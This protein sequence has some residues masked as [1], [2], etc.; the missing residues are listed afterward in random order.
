MSQVIFG[1]LEDLLSIGTPSSGYIVAYDLDGVLKQK[2]V[3]GNI[4]PIGNTS[5]YSLDE[6]LAAGN[7]SGTYS[8]IMGTSS[9]IR[10]A[11]GGG[12]IHFDYPGA[13]AVSITTDGASYSE[14]YLTL[15]GDY[16]KLNYKYSGASGMLLQA[17]TAGE[18]LIN[19]P[20]GTI[21]HVNG[22][23]FIKS[24]V[25]TFS[26]PDTPKYST[27]ISSRGSTVNNGIV[28]SVVL[29]GQN[30][31]ASTNNTVYV[32]SLNVN[33][34]YT[35]PTTDGSN[36]YVLKTDGSGNVTWQSDL[37]TS[38]WA[39]V[40][41]QGN[42]SSADV[43]ISDGNKIKSQDSAVIVDFNNGEKFQAGFTE[44]FTQS[45]VIASATYSRLEFTNQL[46]NNSSYLHM[47]D[48]EYEISASSSI[49]VVGT[50]VSLGKPSLKNTP[51]KFYNSTNS[52]SITLQSGVTTTG[53]TL[54][55]PTSQGGSNT[56]LK[57]DGSGNLIWGTQS[58]SSLSDTLLIGN[59]TSTN[60]VM[61]TGHKLVTSVTSPY[62]VEFTMIGGSAARF[63]LDNESNQTKAW[64]Y[65]DID[66]FESGFNDNYIY[67]DDSRVEMVSATATNA[68]Q[69]KF[70]S[71]S[72]NNRAK[73]GVEVGTIKADSIE[74]V[75]NSS[76][77]ATSTP[78]DKF[79]TFISTRGATAGTAVYNSV[80][81]GGSAMSATQPN[82]VYLGNSVNIN[83]AYT[84]PSTDGTAGY[85]LK[86]NGSG[87]VTWQLDNPGPT[88]SLSQVLG[89]NNT[90]G[91]Y[92]INVENYISFDG[93]GVSQ[94]IDNFASVSPLSGF[95]YRVTGDVTSA[96]YTGSII[97]VSGTDAGT[98]DGQFIVSNATY[99][100][101]YTYF[102]WSG[103][104][105]VIPGPPFGEVSYAREK[106]YLQV[107]AASQSNN[108]NLPNK[109]GTIALLDDIS[110]GTSGTSGTS[111]EA[112]TSGTSG[113][114]GTSGTSGESG[115]S[116]TSG[117]SGTSGTSGANGTSGT[118][119][120]SG[121]SG[122]S[123]ESGT[124]GTSGES[125]T[126][127][128]S[129]EAGTSGTSGSSGT[130]GTSGESGTSGTSGESGTSGT[131]GESGT[132]GTSGESGTSGTSG[133]SGTSGTSGESG[134]SG[135][136]GESG[137][138]GTSGE[139][140]T[141]GTSGESGTSGTS[142]ESGTSGT[143]GESGTSGTSGG[144][145]TSGTSGGSGTSGTSGESGTS[146]TSGESGT[147]G[148]SGES[149]TS[150]TSGES[151]TSGTS[152]ANGTSGTSGESG[153][154]G[155][156][157]ILPVGTELVYAQL[158]RSATF[159]TLLSS[160]S[161]LGSWVT[162]SS[163]N[164]LSGDLSSDV[165]YNGTDKLTISTKSNIVYYS[166]VMTIGCERVESGSN[167]IDIGLAIDGND[168][169]T[170]LYTSVGSGGFSTTPRELSVSGIFMLSSGASHSIQIKARQSSGGV[171]GPNSIRFN[172][173]NLSLI[174]I[175]A[176]ISGTGSA[177]TSGVS[178]TSG[179]SGTNGTSGNTGTSG[180]SGTGFNTISDP[181]N[182][183]IITATGSSTNSAVAQPNLTFDGS[184]LNV[185]GNL[186]VSGSFSVFGSAS[187]I[188]TTNL[189]VSD[190]IIVLAASQSGV[191]TLDSG[192][193]INRGTGATFA[194]IW[195]ESEGVFA[196]IQT[197]SSS[198]VLGNV[199]ISSYANVRAAGATLSGLYITSSTT[200]AFRL[201]DTSQAPGYVL[202]SN[203]TGVGTWTN[204]YSITTATPSLTAVTNV[205]GTSSTDI[206][207]TDATKG[208]IL[209]DS[210]GVRWRVTVSTSGALVTT[211]M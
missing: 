209:K 66:S 196:F 89:I 133:E 25:S 85:V 143:S 61:T 102:Q 132:S 70:T 130:S 81:I 9:I 204:P 178:G 54:T 106:S 110:A 73:I 40:L 166:F 29:G 129:G 26:T 142:G 188:N 176:I 122:T 187:V 44:S 211:A 210:N 148:T 64:F 18:F 177:G 5:T 153:T 68:I 183:R 198:N 206:E 171:A 152:G 92:S 138:S 47:S 121:T 53:Y 105:T 95:Q 135:T 65:G 119:G 43:I 181:A 158:Y 39:Q 97:K 90:T 202:T 113:S 197:N 82:T 109:S 208:I 62:K 168:P 6:V 59:T 111:G 192:F 88:P 42:T 149:G 87:L 4:T 20:A 157:G 69:V 182:Y 128:T 55:L 127:G 101:G 83:N 8:I 46:S 185:T 96:I 139:S 75:N 22:T 136:S 126:S 32:S 98:N 195:D 100:G 156:S 1:N 7:L 37:S 94:S 45:F 91:T 145:G 36:G 35:L 60:I 151:G 174:S 108:Y 38:T 16:I 33:N 162:V 63:L 190:P 17:A 144:S 160:A 11:N 172:S 124:S 165:T 77:G 179:S 120:S 164:L 161:G 93:Q 57:N 134:T 169:P 125:G 31:T 15:A 12:A 137:T 140:G 14:T 180:T 194:T 58:A 74:V 19:S 115:T 147:S 56:Y 27:I 79:P 23:D 24:A 167:A 199:S 51:L 2:D 193:F 78:V 123:G 131:S 50:E 72:I 175:N 189:S 163:S 103:I 48:T 10:S 154:S 205:G 49:S 159:T 86:T 118:S 114:S 67:S 107:N 34:K 201:Q 76:G 30:L 21:L 84:L 146:G 52:N 13:S 186:I 173:L 207:I 104:Q 80:I 28:N 141:S 41:T 3:F 150:G 117:E 191:P 170:D 203:S 116:G 99:S 112:G 71:D 184:T 155:T 200:G